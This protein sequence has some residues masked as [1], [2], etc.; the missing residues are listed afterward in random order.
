MKNKNQE[1]FEFVEVKVC[2]KC[3]KEYP[4]EMFYM[5]RT[6]VRLQCKSCNLA[7]RREYYKNNP[8]AYE[9]KKE[10]QHK[11]RFGNAKLLYKY[12]LEHPCIKC[13]ETDPI[14][15]E[16]DH[17]DPS[18]KCFNITRGCAD[19]KNFDLVLEEISKCDVLCANCHR[20]KSAKQLG[21]FSYKISE[22]NQAE[23]VE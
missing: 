21:Y 5:D 3:N 1:E 17:R 23:M 22:E 14:V 9:Y 6:R 15:L 11:R 16:F 20:R 10:K 7:Y 19:G 2:N 4:I 13:G 18:K 8:H 12:K